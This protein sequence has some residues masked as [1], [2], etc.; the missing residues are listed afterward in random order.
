MASLPK[1]VH[2]IKETMGYN[3]DTSLAAVLAKAA[4]ELEI[5]ITDQTAKGK[6]NRIAEELGIESRC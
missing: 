2:E 1:L 5:E 3:N 6:A 4:S